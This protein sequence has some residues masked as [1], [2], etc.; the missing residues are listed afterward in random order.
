MFGHR[1]IL[2]AQKFPPIRRFFGDSTPA[3]SASPSAGVEVY[4]KTA[5][6]GNLGSVSYNLIQNNGDLIQTMPGAIQV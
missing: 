3:V 1:K 6:N 5:V 2:P 4:V